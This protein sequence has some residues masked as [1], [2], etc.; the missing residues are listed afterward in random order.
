MIWSGFSTIFKG[1]PS[2]PGCPPEFFLDLVQRLW[3]YLGL[4]SSLE[5]EN[6]LLRLFFRCVKS[7]ILS[8]NFSINDSNRITLA[9]NSA[10]RFL[11]QFNSYLFDT[12]EINN[13]KKRS[14]SCRQLL[15]CNKQMFT[16]KLFFHKK[17]KNCS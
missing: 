6:E 15:I 16:M 12:K 1:V 11:S 10:V 14:K 4:F 5:S 17:V 8:S 3:F 2:C 9:S 7:S 13:Y